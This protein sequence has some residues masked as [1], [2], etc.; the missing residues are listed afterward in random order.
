MASPAHSLML[1]L[2]FNRAKE[3][4][5][6]VPLS[7]PSTPHDDSPAVSSGDAFGRG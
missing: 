6:D 5:R 3:L 7:R 4:V 2:F 1:E